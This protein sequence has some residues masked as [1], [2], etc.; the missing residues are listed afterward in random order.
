MPT[1]ISTNKLPGLSPR[2]AQLGG[3]AGHRRRYPDLQ[4]F[5]FSSLNR[6]ANRALA[7]RETGAAGLNLQ[8]HNSCHVPVRKA[9]EHDKI[10]WAAE[11][12]HVLGVEGEIGKIG[13]ELLV[14][15]SGC[16]GLTSLH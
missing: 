14:D 6:I 10:S 16:N 5:D 9:I 12:A 1:S 8:K 7:C 15:F 13:E 4:P 3:S 2:T 11:E